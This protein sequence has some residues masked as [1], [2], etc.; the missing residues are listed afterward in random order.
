MKPVNFIFPFITTSYSVRQWLVYS[1]C[2][3]GITL[4]GITWLTYSQLCILLPLKIECTKLEKEQALHEDEAPSKQKLIFQYK[5][6]KKLY[7]LLSTKETL[8]YKFLLSLAQAI[9]HDMW[10]DE[11]HCI[12][13]KKVVLKGQTYNSFSLAPFITALSEKLP[14]AKISMN[15]FT[16]KEKYF[17]YELEVLFREIR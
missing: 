17:S 3:I 9:G 14:Q 5:N 11:I 10:L 7:K 13:A 12:R 4:L 16:N 8:P 15:N 6:I 2:I 1:L